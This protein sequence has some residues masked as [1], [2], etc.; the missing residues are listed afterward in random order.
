VLVWHT[1]SRLFT[2]SPPPRLRQDKNY[3]LADFFTLENCG[4]FNSFPAPQAQAGQK[5]Q[6]GGFLHFGELR[7]FQLIFKVWFIPKDLLTM[8]NLWHSKSMFFKDTSLQFV[9]KGHIKTKLFL[10]EQLFWKVPVLRALGHP[11]GRV[12]FL[13][14]NN[15]KC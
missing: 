12:F 3:K 9:H 11:F 5:V 15:T 1:Q 2:P 10:F 7:I 4:F 13:Y 14:V 8:V 6:I